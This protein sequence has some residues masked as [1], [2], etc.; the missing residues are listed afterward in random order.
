MFQLA[1]RWQEEDAEI[2]FADDRVDSDGEDPD[3]APY[4]PR[5]DLEDV[6]AAR[7]SKDSS[8][9]D[10][11]CRTVEPAIVKPLAYALPMG[12]PAGTAARTGIR[13]NA[14]PATRGKGKKAAAKPKKD[15]PPTMPAQRGAPR[16]MPVES[17]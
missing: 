8:S 2:A 4:T 16:A 14:P 9:D 13:L 5:V 11:D 15:A 17:G 1:E 10:D 7:A 3:F 6:Q 12:A